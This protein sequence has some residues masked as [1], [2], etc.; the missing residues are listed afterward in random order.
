MASPPV[1]PDRK[2]V[3]A[4]TFPACVRSHL[5]CSGSRER[6][7]ILCLLHIEQMFIA[8]EYT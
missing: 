4:I 8:H 6:Y 1:V 2:K 5:F 3:N 7:L